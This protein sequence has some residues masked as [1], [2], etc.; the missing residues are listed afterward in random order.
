MRVCHNF[1]GAIIPVIFPRVPAKLTAVRSA[2]FSVPGHDFSD[3]C[4]N[5]LYLQILNLIKLF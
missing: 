2:Q 4:V 1:S 5:L 3:D